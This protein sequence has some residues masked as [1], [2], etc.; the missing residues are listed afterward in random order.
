MHMD[1]DTCPGVLGRAVESA[2]GR[3]IYMYIY[4][5]IYIYLELTHTSH[6]KYICI[7][8]YL[9]LHYSPS[10]KGALCA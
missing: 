3:Y 9:Y 8:I 6:L 4:V 7:Y 10:L 2:V 5:Y 1:I